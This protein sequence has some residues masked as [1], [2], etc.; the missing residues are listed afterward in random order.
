[1]AKVAL[2]A[3]LIVHGL[4][5][6]MGFAKAFGLAELRLPWQRTW[7]PGELSQGELMR[8]LAEAPWYPVLR[9]GHGVLREPIDEHSAKATLTDRGVRAMLTFAFNNHG[10]IQSV[11]T[12]ARG[13]S[14]GEPI[15]P[16]PWEGKWWHYEVREGVR[17]PLQPEV[18]RIL[19]EGRKPYWR[20]KVTWS[21]W[22]PCVTSR[23][24]RLGDARCPGAC[25]TRA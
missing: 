6:A 1:M 19:P 7:R 4:V 14:V 24:T 25:R 10:L 16:T 3:R 20:G 18:A 22:A 13:R 11:Q 8:L 5:H 21:R 2:V 15:V 17:V 12:D 23:P 9:P